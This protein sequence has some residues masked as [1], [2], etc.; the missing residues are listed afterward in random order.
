MKG[1]ITVY[2]TSLCPRCQGAKQYLED[3]GIPYKCVD[4]GRD[5]KAAAHLELNDISTLPCI[6]T[7]TCR[8]VGFNVRELDKLIEEVL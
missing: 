2:G 1:Q 7:D 5:L 6:E 3:K 8:V 4:V